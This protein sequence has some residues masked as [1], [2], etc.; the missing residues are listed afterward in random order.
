MKKKLII[1]SDLWGSKDSEW[2]T[3]YSE[4]LKEYF[5]VQFYDCCELGGVT[6]ENSNQE[7]IHQQFIQFGID[8]AV[9]NLL[10]REK[11]PVSI[12]AFSIG[13]TIAWKATL[14]GLKAE[15]I[16]ALSS[17]RLRFE[18]RKPNTKIDLVF[19]EDD[20][21]KPHE[22]WFTQLNLDVQLYKNTSHEFY[23]DPEVSKEIC[24]QITS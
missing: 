6:F 4:I 5:D 10:K 11:S 14:N 13:G 21:N 3:Q 18:S 12:L 20:L 1:L 8:K 19:A 9:T 24:R 17:T 7:S 23:K 16:C 2:I 22:D 15:Y